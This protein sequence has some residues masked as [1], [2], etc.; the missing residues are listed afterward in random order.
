MKIKFWTRKVMHTFIQ[1]WKI[2]SGYYKFRWVQIG[3]FIIIS[4]IFL[5]KNVDFSLHLNAPEEAIE[6]KENEIAKTLE[7]KKETLPPATTKEQAAQKE[8]YFGSLFNEIPPHLMRHLPSQADTNLANTFSNLGFM[9]NPNLAKKLKVSPKVVALKQK[10]CDDYIATFAPI[11]IKEMKKYG[12]PAS[13]TLAQGLLESNVGDSKLATRNNN[14]FGIKC[15]SKNCKHGHCT[16]YTDDSHKDFFRK[17]KNSLESY[18]EHGKFLQKPRYQSLKKYSSTD[19][20]NWAHGLRKAGYA[21]DK[22]YAPKLI[23]I[24]ESLNLQRF[25]S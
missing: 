16:N 25:D 23:K 5:T 14:H 24:I 22:K 10:K 1:N 19:Y 20:R 12:I 11:A 3:T 15:F 4:L 8:K 2:L 7:N 6:M 18:Q 9:L 17:Y 13:V 21:T